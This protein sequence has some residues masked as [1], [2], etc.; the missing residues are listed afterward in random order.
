MSHDGLAEGPGT[1]NHQGRRFM[2]T[3]IRVL[4][5]ISDIKHVLV[6]FS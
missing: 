4:F 6:F 1:D 2:L 3:V 5:S